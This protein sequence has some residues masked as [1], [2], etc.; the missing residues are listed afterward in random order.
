MV[1]SLKQAGECSMAMYAQAVQSGIQFGAL[2]LGA[3]SAETTAAYNST[4][5]TVAGKIAASN[6]RSA[7]E[8][9]IS[10]VNQDKITSNTK[11]R[12]NQDE[13]EAQSRVSAALAGVKGASVEAGIAQTNVN[14]AGAIAA[15]AKAA[16]Q[17]IE[18]LKA[19][20]YGSTMS[21]RARVEQP[22]SSLAGNLMNALSSVDISDFRI[23][24][25]LA[26]EPPT[27]AGTLKLPED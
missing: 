27:D 22:K 13:A 1:N 25:A 2:A 4:Y 6:T 9:N 15:T 16:D 7:G 23:G 26:N 8:R 21:I 19:G 10:A 11:I 17:Q 20:I 24:E 12:Q 3:E 18:Q 5:Q 14:A